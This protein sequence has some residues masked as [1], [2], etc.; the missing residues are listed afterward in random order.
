MWPQSS[1]VML[2][3]VLVS[4]VSISVSTSDYC[5]LTSRHTMCG[6]EVSQA[7]P[8]EIV[9]RHLQGPGPSCGGDL[10]GRGV[11][12]SER[13]LILH[14]HNRLRARLAAGRERRGRP[15]PQPAAA[16]MRLMVGCW[17]D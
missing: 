13:E 1:P 4:L 16:N 8:S 6:Y 12:G 9:S 3:L 15:G 14:V 5:Q 11:T 17:T 10:L 2:V 7:R